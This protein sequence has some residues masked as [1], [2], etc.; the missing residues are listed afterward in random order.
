MWAGDDM[1]YEDIKSIFDRDNELK[2]RLYNL[3]YIIKKSYDGVEVFAV[4]YPNSKKVFSSFDE[5]M[6]KYN[7]FNESLNNFIDNMKVK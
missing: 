2:F 5:A 3:D 6:L 1:K 4:L 7:L